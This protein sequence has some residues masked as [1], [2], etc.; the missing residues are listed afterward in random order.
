MKK[1]ILILIVFLLLAPII[2]CEFDPHGDGG[3]SCE[4]VEVYTDHVYTY[5]LEVESNRV[6]IGDSIKIYLVE[7]R[8]GEY[9]NAINTIDITSYSAV[10]K[11]GTFTHPFIA[12]YIVFHASAP[13]VTTI[14]LEYKSGL[15]TA[16]RNINVDN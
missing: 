7:Y 11:L 13:G 4:T 8:D 10:P 16:S 15:A 14:S 6:K 5:R 12:D 1:I 3:C 9:H 2:A